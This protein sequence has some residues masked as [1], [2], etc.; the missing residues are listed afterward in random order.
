LKADWIKDL[1]A[2]E[3]KISNKI[4]KQASKKALKPLADAI[5]NAAPVETGELKASIKPKAGKRKK[6]FLVTEVNISTADDNIH[7][8]YAEFGTKNEPAKPFIR[9]LAKQMKNEVIDVFF[10]ELEKG[11]S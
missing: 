1:E 10:D 8:A 4:I 9:P 3:K 11:L 5:K 2:M 6:G 7:T